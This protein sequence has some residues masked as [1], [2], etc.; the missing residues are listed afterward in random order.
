MSDTMPLALRT[1][2]TLPTSL[3]PS[4]TTPGSLSALPSSEVGP[5]GSE[6]PPD[7]KSPCDNQLL[8]RFAHLITPS[9]KG[10]EPMSW[11]SMTKPS[12]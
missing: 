9:D 5:S 10:Q 2:A 11:D 7:L 8:C 1:A 6:T 3:T 4:L 12:R